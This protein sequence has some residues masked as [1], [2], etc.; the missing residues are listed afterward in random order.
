MPKHPH[1]DDKH[2]RHATDLSHHTERLGFSI[3]NLD[4]TAD[5]RQDFYRFAAGGWLDQ[6][7]IPDEDAQVGG[8]IGLFHL[9][10]EQILSLL[11]DAADQS[12]DEP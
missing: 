1:H 9:L 5:P 4:P 10:N 7:V 11:Q 6:A 3:D 2:S 8:F 12:A